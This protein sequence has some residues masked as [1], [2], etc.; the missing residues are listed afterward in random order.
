MET[1]LHSQ[2]GPQESPWTEPGMKYLLDNHQPAEREFP[3]G[4]GAGVRGRLVAHTAVRRSPGHADQLTCSDVALG[5]VDLPQCRL[6]IGAATG[7]T[8]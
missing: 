8:G 3:A 4:D 7:S 6:T 1:P 2:E 5:G